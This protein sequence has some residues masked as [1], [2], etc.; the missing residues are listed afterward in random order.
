M[1][2][3]FQKMPIIN[4]SSLYCMPVGKSITGIEPVLH[5]PQM[6]KNTIKKIVSYWLITY[7]YQM[8]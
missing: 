7:I 6:D 2:T 1:Y 8:L 4:E 3:S 5:W